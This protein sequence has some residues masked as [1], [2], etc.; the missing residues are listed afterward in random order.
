MI[1]VV[2]AYDAQQAQGATRGTPPQYQM[3]GG[4]IMQLILVYYDDLL[5][6]FK[7]YIN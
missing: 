2:Q 6:Q 4:G 3:L 7:L 5:T 1:T